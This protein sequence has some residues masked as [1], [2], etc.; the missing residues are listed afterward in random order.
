MYLEMAEAL[1]Q[2]AM[3][4]ADSKRERIN[5]IFRS[6]VTRLPTEEEAVSLTGYYQEQYDRFKNGELKA[7]ELLT[8]DEPTAEGAAW[9]LVARVVLNLDETITNH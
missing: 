6:C 5:H 1:A 3:D 9:T 7:E 8:G 4:Q 2:R